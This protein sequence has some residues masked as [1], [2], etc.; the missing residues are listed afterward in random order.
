MFKDYTLRIPSKDNK[1][2]VVTMARTFEFVP[3][4]F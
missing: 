3:E 4:N 2:S 1:T